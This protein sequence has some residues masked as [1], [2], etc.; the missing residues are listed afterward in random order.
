M[1]V[2]ERKKVWDDFMDSLQNNPEQ[3]VTKA[4]LFKA[5][6]YISEDIG[7]LAQMSITNNSN[8]VALNNKIKP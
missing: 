4:D 7:T 1:T 2:E 6:D 8:I 3:I 5:L